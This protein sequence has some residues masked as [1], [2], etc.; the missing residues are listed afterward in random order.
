MAGRGQS[1]LSGET[2]ERFFFVSQQKES[3]DVDFVVV[4]LKSDGFYDSRLAC[5]AAFGAEG[6]PADELVC[7]CC[8]CCCGRRTLHDTDNRRDQSMCLSYESLEKSTPIGS[9]ILFLM[10]IILM[11]INVSGR[12]IVSGDGGHSP[13]LHQPI[14]A[15]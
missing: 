3:V 4:P 15:Y 7:H 8:C 5:Q 9:D 2:L 12:L 1:R 11:R 6:Q 14:T 10:E 13:D